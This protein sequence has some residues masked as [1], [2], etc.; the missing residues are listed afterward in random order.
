MTACFA[1]PDVMRVWEHD[2]KKG[3]WLARLRSMLARYASSEPGE[4]E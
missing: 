3:P 2:I 4:V 1:T